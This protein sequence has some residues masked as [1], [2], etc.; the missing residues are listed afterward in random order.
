LVFRVINNHNLTWF[1]PQGLLLLINV[2]FL[3]FNL[4]EHWERSGDEIFYLV[5]RS[6]THCLPPRVQVVQ[7]AGARGGD[8]V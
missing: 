1:S 8:T 5:E 3:V 6:P 2:T 7:G 4:E